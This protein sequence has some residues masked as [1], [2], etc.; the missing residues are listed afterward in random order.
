MPKLVKLSRKTS[1]VDASAFQ[2]YMGEDPPAKRWYPFE[3]KKITA[4]TS[5][6]G[7]PMI[8]LLL[9]LKA[10]KGSD[11][12][13]YNGFTIVARVVMT[14]NEYNIAREQGLYVAVAG[15]PDVEITLSDSLENN[16]EVDVKKIGTT[17]PEGKVILAYLKYKP[18]QGEY[19][20]GVEVDGYAK[21]DAAS[22]KAA[23]SSDP[24]EDEDDEEVEGYSEE[25][26]AKKSIQA[27]RK[28]LTEEFD[29]DATGLK[30]AEL[31]EAILEAQD[32]DEEDE[33]D[34]DEDEEPEEELED[35]EDEDEEEEEDERRAELAELSRAE[36]RTRVK[37]LN[38]KFRVTASVTEDAMIDE[39]LRLEPPF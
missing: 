6:S 15:K 10:P 37:K 30:K 27:L 35:E 38:P 20:A 8:V 12:E 21:Y 32:G 11:S 2:P 1:A 3:I 26:L 4:R 19:P 9:S 13:Q 34:E 7:N 17:S 25:E 16:D 14:D 24:D 29:G 33:E 36:L 18:A 22:T 31:V 39:I 5:S 23:K 28:I